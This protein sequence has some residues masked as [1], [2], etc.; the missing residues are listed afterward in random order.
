M[1]LKNQTMI[2]MNLLNIKYLA[3]QHHFINVYTISNSTILFKQ[4]IPPNSK[5]S[6]YSAL[7]KKRDD[8]REIQKTI[9]RLYCNNGYD[10]NFK[11]QLKND[12]KFNKMIHH[13]MNYIQ[14]TLQSLF[15]NEILEDFNSNNNIINH[16][17]Q[18]V[19]NIKRITFANIK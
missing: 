4:M 18:I 15:N 9:S 7:H 17:H 14:H 13:Q 11:S 16:Q 12:F 19:C 10:V 3:N 5:V 1:N 2:L 8:I 6:V